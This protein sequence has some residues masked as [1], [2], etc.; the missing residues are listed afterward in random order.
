MG[1]AALVIGKD[2]AHIISWAFLGIIV[3]RTVDAILGLVKD[4]LDR[5]MKSWSNL[6]A[7]WLNVFAQMALLAVVPAVFCMIRLRPFVQDW[8]TS[9]PG[10]FFASFF[11][12]MQSNL[13]S[14]I[15][16]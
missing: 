3:G 1:K 13:L 16:R 10:L 14:T 8:Q 12:G 4:H 2:Y 15:Q 6:L 9:T 5:S 7:K 11:L